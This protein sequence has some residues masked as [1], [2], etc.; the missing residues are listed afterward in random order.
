MTG[1]SADAAGAAGEEV[2]TVHVHD[3]DGEIE[4]LPLLERAGDGRVRVREW[5]RG[6]WAEPAV[7][8]AMGADEVYD[9][10]RR[11]YDER[12]R[13]SVTPME[14]RAWLDGGRRR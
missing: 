10:V 7:E 13:V 14:L 3:V 1:R 2:L 8:R 9:V 4:R 5:A 6:A 11:A 12:R